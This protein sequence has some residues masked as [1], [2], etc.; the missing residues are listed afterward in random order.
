MVFADQPDM[1][2]RERMRAEVQGDRAAVSDGEVLAVYIGCQGF[3][4]KRGRFYLRKGGFGVGSS[5]SAGKDGEAWGDWE[6]AALLTALG[7]IEGA[8]RRARKRR[9]G[10]GG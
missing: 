5:A 10:G 1:E 9:G 3:G 8:R 6:V 7:V 4:R 2:L